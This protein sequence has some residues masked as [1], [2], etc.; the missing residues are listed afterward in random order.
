VRIGVTGAAGFLGRSVVE[1]CLRR[2]HEVAALVRDT[3][4]G[5]LP[6][7]PALT[8]HQWDLLR[9]ADSRLPERLDSVLHLAAYVP[10][11]AGDAGEAEAC[12]RHNAF[13]VRDFAQVVA[14]SGISH[15]VLAS[16]GSLYVN[17]GKPAGENDPVYPAV[18]ATYYL[19]SKL[20]GEAFALHAAH[21]HHVDLATLR[22]G[23]V[24]GPGMRTGS[25]VARFLTQIAAGQPHQIERGGHTADFVFVGDVASAFVTAAE[26]RVTGVFNVGSGVATSIHALSLAVHEA[27]GRTAPNA[28]D[29][30]RSNEPSGF[31]ALDISSAMANLGLSP[32]PL[33]EGLQKTAAAF[34][35]A[36]APR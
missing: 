27:S 36:S 16:T 20:A 29:H 35:A 30:T 5:R 10:S 25:V 19:A 2:G 6:G 11:R 33:L 31:P 9:S 1:E 12:M 32:T 34:Y 22:I 4:D 3:Q 23:S 13:A 17:H 26:K 21:V 18:H 14:Q 7:H 8:A 28:P 15:F 24:Y